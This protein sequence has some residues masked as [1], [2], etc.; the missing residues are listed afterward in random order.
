MLD[1]RRRRWVDVV[2]MLYKF[3]VFAGKYPLNLYLNVIL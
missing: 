2:Q 3:F 1:Q